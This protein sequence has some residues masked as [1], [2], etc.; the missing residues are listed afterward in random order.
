MLMYFIWFAVPV[1][2]WIAILKIFFPDTLSWEEVGVQAGVTTLV[3][4]GLFFAA[5]HSQ[6]ADNLI[7][8]GIVTKLEPRQQSCPR[9]WRNSRDS[10]CTEYRTRSRKVGESCSTI[11]GTRTCT[12]I[13]TTDYKYIY[14]WERRYFV[15]ADY[16]APFN[17]QRYEVARVDRQGVNT[18]P[19]FAETEI[20]DPTAMS[21]GYTNYIKGASSS[22]FAEEAPGEEVVLA[23][24]NIRQQWRTNRVLTFGFEFDSNEWRAW[25][26]DVM[27]LNTDLRETGGNV[28]IALAGR[29]RH[30]AEMLARAWEAHNINDVVVAIGTDGTDIDWVD[31]RSWSGN[32]L[33][34]IEIRDGIMDLGTL[35][36]AA[37]NAIIADAMEH[38]ELKS[39]D[40]FE[41]LA[42]DIVPPTWVMVLAGIIL[43]IVTPAITYLF[44]RI[45]L[46][47]SRRRW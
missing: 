46:F 15:F 19:R 36:R 5:G 3:I 39:M 12:P 11:N 45:D 13:Y 33:V 30:F 31:V 1:L 2:V 9:G 18:P 24:P 43:V 35:D 14:D 37:I 25:N 4:A 42:D 27:Q 8:N 22:L 23:Y 47:P 26:E 10:H 17:D 7:A 28:V 44:H 20:G 16:E 21:V 40:E 41:Y 34:E 32:S 29:D 6:T 38:F